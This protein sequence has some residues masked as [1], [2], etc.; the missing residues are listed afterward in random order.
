MANKKEETTILE[1]KGCCLDGEEMVDLDVPYAPGMLEEDLRLFRNG[2]PLTLRRG[3]K[4]KIPEGYKY[5]YD[6]SIRIQKEARDRAAK[7]Q[8]EF[9]EAGK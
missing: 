4:V 2:M 7:L 1:A 6:R 3:D 8:K 9:L 5:I